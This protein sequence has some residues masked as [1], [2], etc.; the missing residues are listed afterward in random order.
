[1][2]ELVM[3]N[4]FPGASRNRFVDDKYISQVKNK[5]YRQE[6]VLEIMQLGINCTPFIITQPTEQG[7]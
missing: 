6:F 7:N 5:F 1:M 4:G 3:Y 2:L